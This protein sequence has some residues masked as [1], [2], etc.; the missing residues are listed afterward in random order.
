MNVKKLNKINLHSPKISDHTSII[1]KEKKIRLILKTFQ[2]QFAA[3][4]T[5]PIIEGRDCGSVVLPKADIKFFFKCNLNIAAKRRFNEFKK[6]NSSINLSAVKKS[7]KIRNNRDST[8]KIS[9]LLKD[10]PDF[11]KNKRTR[12]Q[13]QFSAGISGLNVPSGFTYTGGKPG[14]GTSDEVQA[15]EFYPENEDGDSLPGL[16]PLDA[17]APAIEGRHGA[18]AGKGKGG[19][20]GK[21]KS[22]GKSK[23]PPRSRS[24]SSATEDSGTGSASAAASS[25]KPS[26]PFKRLSQISQGKSPSP[27]KRVSFATDSNDSEAEP[28]AKKIK[29]PKL[30]YD[31]MKI[32][33]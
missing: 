18:P 28:G 25:F 8:R 13:T 20:K 30:F 3:K 12:R 23:S 19:K 14:V 29:L 32:L 9:P 10:Q 11:D 7:I 16:S 21:G 31:M 6:I 1:A 33:A 4:T 17:D 22:K 2:R 26:D 27:E 24:S 5:K 15:M